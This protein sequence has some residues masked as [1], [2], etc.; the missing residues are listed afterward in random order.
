MIQALKTP[1]NTDELKEIYKNNSLVYYTP[2]EELINT[3]SHALGVVFAVVMLILMLL[4]ATTVECVL[5]AVL[6]CFCLGL[7]FFISTKY[8]GTKDLKKKLMWRKLDFPAVNLNVIACG[9]S[10]CLLYGNIYGYI[11]FGVS[12]V[13]SIAMLF[14]CLFAFDKSHKIS[15]GSTFIVGALLFAAFFVANFTGDGIRNKDL[16]G[17]LYLAGLL[18]SLLGAIFFRIYK[19]YMHSVFHV[20]VLIGPMLCMLANYYQ[21]I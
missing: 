6:S 15:V 5:T 1:D 9:T 20:L 21:L 8:H 4:R 12:F 17:Y 11:A 2:L 14:C 3:V 16:V 7:E 18:A 10:L 13:L 19:R